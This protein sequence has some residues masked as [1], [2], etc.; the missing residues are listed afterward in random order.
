VR[1]RSVGGLAR[2]FNAY[3][4]RDLLTR[5]YGQ[6]CETAYAACERGHQGQCVLSAECLLDTDRKQAQALLENLCVDGSTRACELA[7][8]HA[9]TAGTA[10]MMYGRGC[11][12]GS[13]PACTGLAAAEQLG[14]GV[15]R[16][17]EDALV[18]FTHACG[19]SSTF[20]ACHAVAGYLPV[21]WLGR[22]RLS[23]GLGETGLPAPDTGRLADLK[24]E[25]LERDRTA[26]AGFCLGDDGRPQD[27][28][29]LQSW[30][31]AR[32]DSVVLDAVR[33]GRFG[34]QAGVEHRCW[35]M[36]YRVKFR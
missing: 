29:M 18:K 25:L 11:E 16:D 26:V 5:R 2:D 24:W 34:A 13:T 19:V 8:D 21:T 33:G 36:T 31:D 35:W 12:L 14:V 17:P 30:G 10:A 22:A 20:E 27:V 28:K 3:Y 32:V 7:G 9:A 1:R 23:S 15:A 4:H 6:V